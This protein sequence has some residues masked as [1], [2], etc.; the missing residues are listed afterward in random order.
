MVL[1][2][3]RLAKS[4]PSFIQTRPA[5]FRSPCSASISFVHPKLL[6]LPTRRDTLDIHYSTLKEI[7]HG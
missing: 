6:S 4:K 2:P 1:L 3:F 5:A 7:P